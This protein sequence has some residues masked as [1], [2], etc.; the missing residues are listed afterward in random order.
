MEIVGKI[1][2]AAYFREEASSTDFVRLCKCSRENLIVFIGT[3]YFM[4]RV[5][6]N[7]ICIFDEYRLPL[8]VTFRCIVRHN[9]SVPPCYAIPSKTISSLIGNA[10][11]E[12]GC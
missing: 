1:L 10:K 3:G 11:G 4:H 8:H 9:V 12:K 7:V 2:C 6:V 5:R